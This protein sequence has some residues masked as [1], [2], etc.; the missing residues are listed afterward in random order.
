MKMLSMH[1]PLLSME[2]ATP[3][4]LSTAVNPRLVNWLP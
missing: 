2:M 3:E 4:A 1:R